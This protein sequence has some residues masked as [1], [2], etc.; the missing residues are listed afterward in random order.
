MVLPTSGHTW[1]TVDPVTERQNN[2]VAMALL[3]VV[4]VYVA[5]GIVRMAATQAA[6][7][8]VAA[9]TAQLVLLATSDRTQAMMDPG[10]EG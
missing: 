8:G 7:K 2:G 10:R 1:A 6:T 5:K 4:V 9:V 3:P